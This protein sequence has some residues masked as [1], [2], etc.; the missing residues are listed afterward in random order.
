MDS[1]VEAQR[2]RLEAYA[3]IASVIMTEI[4]SGLMFCRIAKGQQ[5]GGTRDRTLEHARKAYTT[6]ESGMWKLKTSHA[7]FDP[8]IAPLELLKCELRNVCAKR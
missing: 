5:E 6:A 1:L 4:E 8:I 7:E 3:T 2:L